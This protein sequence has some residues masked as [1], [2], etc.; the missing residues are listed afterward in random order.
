MFINDIM[1][2][3]FILFFAFYFVLYFAVNINHFFSV[4]ACMQ[5]QSYQKTNLFL[6]LK[7]NV[8][9]LIVKRMSKKRGDT[10]KYAVFNMKGLQKQQ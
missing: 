4:T 2:V 3:Y 6:K 7:L 5:N 10:V 9:Y 8:N 1:K